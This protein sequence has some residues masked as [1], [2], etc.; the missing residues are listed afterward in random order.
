MYINCIS[1]D[2]LK[3]CNFSKIFIVSHTDYDL[4]VLSIFLSCFAISDF[5]FFSCDNN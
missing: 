3:M 1:P 5:P 2:D 4:D